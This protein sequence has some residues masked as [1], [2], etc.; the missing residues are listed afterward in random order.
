M[1]TGTGKTITAL[2]AIEDIVQ[3]GFTSLGPCPNKRAAG[4]VANFDKVVLSKGSSSL[5]RRRLRLEGSR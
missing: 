5:R 3:R 2:L 4:P 1:A